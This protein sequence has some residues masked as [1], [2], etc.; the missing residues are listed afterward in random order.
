MKIKKTY[1]AIPV[2]ILAIIIVGL[3]A[4]QPANSIT[5]DVNPSI[6]LVTNRLD[7]VMEINPLNKDAK[8]LLEGFKPKDKNLENTV[9]DLVD[10]MILSGHIKGGKDN[11]VMITVE[12]DSIDSKLVNKVND[13]IAA[14]LENK[15]IEATVINQGITGSKKD[16]K[17]TGVQIAAEKLYEMDKSLTMRE[18][19]NMTV[20]ELV[21]YSKNKNLPIES[22]FKVIVGN[23]EK[24]NQSKNIISEKRAKEI[25]LEIVNGKISKI[26]LVNLNNSKGEYAIEILLENGKYI[27]LIDAYTGQVMEFRKE[28]DQSSSQDKTKEPISGRISIEEAKKIA[29]AKVG[30]GTV[31]EFELDDD[32]YEI[33]IKKDGIEYEIE[34]DAYT[35]EIKKFEKDDDDDDD[36]DLDD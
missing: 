19:E 18:I 26:E 27:I 17:Q 8:E 32:E 28:E 7:R 2:F 15:R 29:L 23:I 6:E 16:E 12:D 24:A 35:S 31:T 33:E 10:L 9:N 14:L 34:I 20:K 4:T 22:L 30:G 5:M 36:D 11:F 21:N 3:V 25:A 1:Y 13:A